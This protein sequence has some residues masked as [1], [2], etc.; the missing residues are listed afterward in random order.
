VREAAEAAGLEVR[1]LAYQA[2]PAFS[3]EERAASAP[4]SARS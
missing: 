3:R 4:P 1:A 2:R